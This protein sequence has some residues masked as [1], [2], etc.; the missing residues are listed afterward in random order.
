L[1]FVEEFEDR[2]VELREQGAAAITFPD[3]RWA[4]CDIKSTNLL[5]NLLAAQ[6]AKEAG[7]A[8]ALLYQADDTLVEGARTS[9][10]GV[11]EGS[12]RTAPISDDILPG[13][14]RELIL[15]L[16]G[17]QSVPVRDQPIRRAD[18]SRVSELFVTGTTSE[19]LPIV[20]VDQLPIGDGRPGAVTR[21]L[22]EAYR[23]AVQ[24]RVDK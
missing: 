20:R 15:R 14:T 10:F 2:Y 8:E 11:L 1:L 18:L 17:E 6:A 4:R 16:A 23:R 19:I 5:G 22:Q 3:I 9:L 7:A 21:K 24:R 13:I 12:L